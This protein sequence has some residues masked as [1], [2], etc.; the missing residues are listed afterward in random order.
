M[1]IN[2][3]PR[4]PAP[5]RGAA[6]DSPGASTSRVFA[7]DLA[8][9]W[10]TQRKAIFGRNNMRRLHSP[11]TLRPKSPQTDS[12]C[13]QADDLLRQLRLHILQMRFGRLPQRIRN[14]P[15]IRLPTFRP[16]CY[17][18]LRDQHD[19]PRI[20]FGTRSS[21]GI[22]APDRQRAKH[23]QAQQEQLRSLPGLGGR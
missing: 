21:R 3:A 4:M 23:R 2:G 8:P 9:P 5:E 10:A 11:Q 12:R 18:R 17:V 16:P 14:D 7:S 6:Y 19:S 1:R 22:G 15:D 20:P 13:A